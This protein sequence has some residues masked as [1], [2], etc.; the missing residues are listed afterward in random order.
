MVANTNAQ[1]PKKDEVAALRRQVLELHELMGQLNN[2]IQ[3]QYQ[4][5]QEMKKH[6]SVICLEQE[7]HAKF[8]EGAK[9]ADLEQAVQKE[10]AKVEAKQRKIVGVCKSTKEQCKNCLGILGGQKWRTCNYAYGDYKGHLK[11]VGADE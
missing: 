10:E 6:I 1:S 2:I 7:K 9:K 5:N 11:L 4:F 3:G 8:I